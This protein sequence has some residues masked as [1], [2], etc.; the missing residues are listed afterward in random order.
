VTEPWF[1]RHARNVTRGGGSAGA[2]PG[3]GG[4]PTAVGAQGSA[5]TALF[6]PPYGWS[7]QHGREAAPNHI[8]ESPRSLGHLTKP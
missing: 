5:P 1:L 6:L 7:I 4:A 2:G 3:V 8:D